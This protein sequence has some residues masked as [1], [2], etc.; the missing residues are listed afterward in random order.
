MEHLS[1]PHTEL[2]HLHQL[3]YKLVA[4]E[5]TL[6][7][8]SQ[9]NHLLSQKTTYFFFPRRSGH[10]RACVLINKHLHA[11]K[12]MQESIVLAFNLPSIPVN[13][14]DTFTKVATS[15]CPTLTPHFPAICIYAAHASR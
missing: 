2:L 8:V 1:C 3:V 10:D 6:V 7:E 9:W 13:D 14:S 4:L 12:Y 5:Q 15:H 11:G